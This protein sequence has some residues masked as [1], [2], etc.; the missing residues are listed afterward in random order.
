MMSS[1]TDSHH[2][3]NVSRWTA[4]ALRIEIEPVSPSF[5]CCEVLELFARRAG[6]PAVAIALAPRCFGLVDRTGFLS[7]LALPYRKELYSRRPITELMDPAPLVVVGNTRIEQVA[8][9]ITQT[10]PEA[11]YRGFVIVDEAGDYLG[12]GSGLDLMVCMNDLMRETLAEL[13]SSQSKLI[14]SEKMAALGS[15]VAGVAHEINTPVGIA[16]TAAS[17]LHEHTQGIHRQL[18]AGQIKKSD[19][20][21][22]LDL[23]IE[24]THMML[25]NTARAADLIQSFKQVAVDQTSSQQRCFELKPY[26]D[27]ILLNLRPRLKKTRHVI[28][29]DCQSKLRL[30]TYPGDLSQI[31]TNLIINSLDHG[32]ADKHE[33]GRISIAVKKL[34]DRRIEIN[35]ADNGVGIPAPNQAKVFEPFFT[36]RRSSGGSGLGLHIVYNLVT[37]RLYGEIQLTSEVGKFTRFT[38]ICP[39][40]ASQSEGAPLEITS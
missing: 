40:L 36:T 6:I 20:T 38:I 35:Y 7:T 33:G 23:A 21:Q 22:Y 39:C 14:E 18:Q 37:Q 15:L 12:L 5:H 32:L 24:S 16:R 26:L 8:E 19:L 27:E 25:T 11:L 2:F 17:H 34:D 10:K 3:D 9:R 1:P 30:L 13:R 4:A 31:F 29:I 28:D